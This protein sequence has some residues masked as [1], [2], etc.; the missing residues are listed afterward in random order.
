M[1]DLEPATAE[2][3]RIIQGVRDEQLAASTPCEESSVGDLLDHVDGLS[4]A[5]TAAATKTVLPGDQAPAPDASNLGPDW[6]TRIPS[7]LADLADAWRDEA[8]WSGMT[9]VGGQD[10]PAEVVGV[11]ALDEVI[12]HAWDL[13]V[14]TGQPFSWEPQL[15]EAAYGF[16]QPI[17]AQSPEGVP[18]LFGPAVSVHEDAPLFHRL[19]GLTGRDP[20][21]K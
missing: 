6:R 3:A 14:A 18:G 1:I 7:R 10:M 17:A 21:W 2:L 15:V 19:L 5:F 9:H 8:A 4:M 13:A 11:V 20:A 12:I 16:V